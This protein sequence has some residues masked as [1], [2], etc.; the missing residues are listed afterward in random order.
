MIV[1][2][3][4]ADPELFGLFGFS[5]LIA[6]KDKIKAAAVNGV[7]PS[8]KRYSRLFISNRKTIIFYVKKAHIGVVPGIH[9]YLKEF[10]AKKAMGPEGYL[11][12]VG[13]VPLSPDK[14]K[15]TRTSA[16]K[17]TTIKAIN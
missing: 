3:L 15:T 10:T 11:T 2:K 16:L 4:S 8:L 1:N 17:L 9:E 6:N 7:K 14:Y 13:L 5:Y 12:D